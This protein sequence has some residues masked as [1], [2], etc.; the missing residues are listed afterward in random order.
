VPLKPTRSPV[1]DAP[2]VDVLDGRTAD[3]G[4]TVTRLLPTVGRRS[5]G[6]WVFADHFGPARV[7]ADVRVPPHPHCGLS[8]VTWILDG[9]GLHKD[10]LGTTQ[11]L[12]PGEVNWMTA[13]RGITHS[14]EMPPGDLH[15]LQLWVALPPDQWDRPPSFEHHAELPRIATDQGTAT[16]L[17][18]RVAIDGTE[19]TSPTT[20]HS[21][22]LAV[23]LDLTGPIAIEVAADHEHGLL[24]VEGEVWVDG[25][26]IA[27]DQLGYLGTRRDVVRIEVRQAARCM[28]L[29]GEP[30][31]APILVWWNFVTPSFDALIEAWEDWGD[32]GA[33]FEQRFGAVPNYT[34]GP[35]LSAPTLPGFA[36]R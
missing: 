12:R 33:R 14:E 6:P 3:V 2:V 15:G 34:H 32:E 17:A 16:V 7:D 26:R 1:T 28:L 22:T 29:G 9:E 18:G 19:A 5:I 31:R 27:T 8:T 23:D 21:P 25:T 4:M 30:L 20:V 10:S 35:R 36:G 11:R 13:G 24:V